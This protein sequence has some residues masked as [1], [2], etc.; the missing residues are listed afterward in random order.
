MTGGDPTR[1]RQRAERLGRLAEALAAFCLR[2]KGYRVLARRHRTKV[3]E[4]DLVLCR[5]PILVFV[6]IKARRDD[7][8][9]PEVLA[10]AQRRRIEAA[11]RAFVQARPDLAGLDW[12]FDLILVTRFLRLHHLEDAWRPGLP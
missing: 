3:G 2:L 6:E 11:A 10:P 9:T 5:G 4:I 8:A 7:F 12:R 1:S